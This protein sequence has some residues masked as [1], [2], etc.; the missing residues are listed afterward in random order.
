MRKGL[1]QLCFV[2]FLF[3]S[4]TSTFSLGLRRRRLM[5]SSSYLEVLLHFSS[6]WCSEQ[7]LLQQ[8]H[9]IDYY[10]FYSY[11]ISPCTHHPS[12]RTHPPN[13]Y[14]DSCKVLMCFLLPFFFFLLLLLLCWLVSA[15]LVVIFCMLP[16]QPPI[17]S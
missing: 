1:Q 4:S 15:D 17:V 5:L 11:D 6:Q 9:R 2:S 16:T 3:F 14:S 8:L 13:S 12:S 7:I 10:L